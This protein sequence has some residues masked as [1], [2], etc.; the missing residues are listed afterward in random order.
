MKLRFLVFLAV[1][2][3]FTFLVFGCIQLDLL[4]NP[5]LRH[6]AQEWKWH[7]YFTSGHGLAALYLQGWLWLIPSFIISAI[8]SFFIVIVLED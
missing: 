1:F 8:V 6:V 7:S 2:A 4:L 3:I 5:W